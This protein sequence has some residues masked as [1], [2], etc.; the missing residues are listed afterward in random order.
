MGKGTL[1]RLEDRP[2]VVTGAAQGIGLEIAS[3]L[4][5][6]GADVL[7]FDLDGDAAERAAKE[8]SGKHGR[9]VEA[10][11]GNV[12]SS[13]DVDGAIE[14]ATATV[15]PPRLLVNCA[16][17][18]TLSL[19]VDTDDEEWDRIVDV[20]LK[21]TFLFVRAFARELL[22][23]Q[24]TGAVVNIASLNATAA[25]DGLGHYCAA[26]AGVSMLTKVAASE[27]GAHGIRVNAIAPGTTHTP[28]TEQLG[29]VSGLM[30]EAFREHTPA[31][32]LGQPIDI[33]NAAVFLCSDE[34]D[35]ITGVTLPVDGGNH[36]RGLFSYWD[37]MQAQL[38]ESR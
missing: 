15:G 8:L 2:A 19:I 10:I 27:L 24:L 16:G 5:A 12:T 29:T 36:V 18:A 14:R 4:A 9:R 37:T 3:Q 38:A 31:G 34:A 6:N 21:G 17:T 33:A 30:G 7:I 32:R 1:L 11:A 20:N 26:K 22:K 25:T 35:W 23:R 13:A 28:L